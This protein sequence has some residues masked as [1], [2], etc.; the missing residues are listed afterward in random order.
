VNLKWVNF[1]GFLKRGDGSTVWSTNVINPNAR[2]LSELPVGMLPMAFMLSLVIV[3]D[4]P[5][6]DLVE[7]HQPNIGSK[8]GFLL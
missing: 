6:S 3:K 2:T 8:S 5:S 1:G 4:R 7:Y